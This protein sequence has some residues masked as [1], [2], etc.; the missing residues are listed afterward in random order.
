MFSLEIPKEILSANLD[1][2]GVNEK[3]LE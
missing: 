2:C 1:E 3:E